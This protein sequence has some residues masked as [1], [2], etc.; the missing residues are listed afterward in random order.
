MAAMLGIFSAGPMGDHQIE[1]PTTQQALDSLTQHFV[2][3]RFLIRPV[4]KVRH[5]TITTQKL[6]HAPE[7]RSAVRI[8]CTA[9]GHD[10]PAPFGV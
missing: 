9:Q 2:I 8:A 10:P 5:F 4:V 1:L 6:Q 7:F 3:Q